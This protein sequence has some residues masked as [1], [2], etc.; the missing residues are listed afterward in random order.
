MVDENESS[1]NMEDIYDDKIVRI[2]IGDDIAMDMDAEES[3]G[4]FDDVVA[5]ITTAIDDADIDREETWLRKC[6]G[7]LPNSIEEKPNVLT[8]LPQGVQMKLVLDLRENEKANLLKNLQECS[9]VV[10]RLKDQLYKS[11]DKRMELEY[12]LETESIEVKKNE[13]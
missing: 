6:T 9:S 11:E 4:S 3:D 1:N 7:E 8:S 13:A 5:C 12:E 10:E 2:A